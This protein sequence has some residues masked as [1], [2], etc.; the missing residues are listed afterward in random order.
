MTLI[1]VAAIFELALYI[2]IVACVIGAVRGSKEEAYYEA[3]K[4]YP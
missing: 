2:L 3:Q 1:I 4:V